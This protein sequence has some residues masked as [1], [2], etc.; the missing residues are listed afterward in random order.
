MCSERSEAAR[1]AFS[2]ARAVF[3]S[4][5]FPRRG[6]SRRAGRV[7][8]SGRCVF[9]GHVMLRPLFALLA[10][11]SF[12]LAEP[13]LAEAFDSGTWTSKPNG[14]DPAVVQLDVHTGPTSN[15]GN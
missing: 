3:E 8:S 12:V 9:G 10:V 15:F 7:C 2:K 4:S 1:R 14:K 5:F 13:A 11:L 6:R